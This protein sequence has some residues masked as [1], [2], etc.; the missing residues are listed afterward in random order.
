[1]KKP[2]L[3]VC[4]TL[5]LAACAAPKVT[6]VQTLSESADAP[7]SNV[8]VVTLFESFDIR[9]YFEGEIVKQ[10][11]NKGVKA[12]ASTSMMNTK[13]P[14]NKETVLAIVDKTGS[15]SVL[16]TQL[17][18]LETASKVREANPESTYNVRPTHYY[19]VWN[20]ELT[21][22]EAPPG[23]E[24]KHTYTMAIEMFSVSTVSPVW[25]IET[26]SKLSRDI[27]QNT[28]GTTAEDEAKGIVNAMWRDGLLAR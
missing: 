19:N 13:T 16:V 7:Y 10:L 20:V 1:V 14:V 24:L 3:L 2:V 26:T 12:V 6:R 5:F 8:L 17:V 23:L 27:N 28:S 21:E 4:V 22:Y 25:A 15:D 9:R 11:E 18:S